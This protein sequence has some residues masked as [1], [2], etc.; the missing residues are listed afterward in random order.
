M[1]KEQVLQS[2][3]ENCKNLDSRNRFFFNIFLKWLVFNVRKRIYLYLDCTISPPYQIEPHIGHHDLI[4]LIHV[5]NLLQRQ[6]ELE[7]GVTVT[8]SSL[9]S[10]E[11]GWQH[12]NYE[13]GNNYCETF[14]E[15]FT[16]T[17]QILPTHFA[18]IYTKAATKCKVGERS[19]RRNAADSRSSILVGK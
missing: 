8:I 3:W 2:F 7:R 1:N 14:L 11:G 6:P 16:L 18:K 4:L 12:K 13:P 9:E 10:R 15:S 17:I 19:L 5:H